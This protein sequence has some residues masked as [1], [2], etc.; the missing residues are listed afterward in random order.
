M[1]WA[2][3]Y[4]FYPADQPG[5]TASLRYT[6]IDGR[7][8]VFGVDIT[9]A[10]LS[11]FLGS[12]KIGKTGRAMIIDGDGRMIAHPQLWR[13][14]RRGGDSGAAGLITARIHE[15]AHDVSARAY[16]PVRTQGPRPRSLPP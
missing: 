6:G 12:L 3:V 7:V 11:R 1:P 13:I 8:F 4:A 14:L 15:I 16:D 10:E 5:V 2:E 9:L